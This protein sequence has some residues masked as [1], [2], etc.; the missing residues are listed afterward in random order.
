MTH[1]IAAAEATRGVYE[2]ASGTIQT[3]AWVLV[4]LPALGAA[5]L[6]LGGRRTD[7]WGHWLGVATVTASFVVGVL[8]FLDTLALAPEQRVRELSLF[9][10]F[11]VGALQV[12]FGL[13]LRR[14]QRGLRVLGV[15]RLLGHV[16]SSGVTRAGGL[17]WD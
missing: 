16:F 1:L 2:A 15:G 14:W 8:V 5:V 6:L 7:R 17:R 13:R 9:R 3:G 12:D 4:A 10:W 11:G